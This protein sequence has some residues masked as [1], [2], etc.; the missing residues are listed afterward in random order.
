M[1]ILLSILALVA[2]FIVLLLIIALFS[3][4]DYSVERD[5]VINRP[6][7]EVFEYIKHL[8]NQDNFSKWVMTDPDMKKI[9]TGNDGTIGFIYAWEGN[10]KAGK[11]EQEIINIKPDERIDIEVR[12]EKPFAGIASAPF[13]TEKVADGQTRLSWGLRSKMNYPM[14]LMLLFMN[15]D[16]MLGNDMQQSLVKLKGILEK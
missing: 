8:K 1:N 4:K 6:K 5:I 10:K 11:G 3:R 9:F 13:S 12:F 15:I 14:N 2:V 7:E 16:K